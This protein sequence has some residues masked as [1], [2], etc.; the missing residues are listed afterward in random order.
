MDEEDQTMFDGEDA[1]QS[2]AD[3]TAESPQDSRNRVRSYGDMYGDGDQ[4]PD[5]WR[6]W[7]YHPGEYKEQLPKDHGVTTGD[8]KDKNKDDHTENSSKV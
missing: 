3:G 2:V 1:W 6:R 8:G 7:R 5:R 4:H